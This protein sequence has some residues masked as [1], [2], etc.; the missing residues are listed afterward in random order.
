MA[1]NR[2]DYGQIIEQIVYD[3][4][5]YRTR[6]KVADYIP[7]LAAVP[8]DKFGIAIETVDGR[9]FQIGDAAE[10]FSIQSI[11]KL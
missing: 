3:C 4:A 2:P 5:P 9:S 7:A 8:A 10:R 11:S 1:S 6:G